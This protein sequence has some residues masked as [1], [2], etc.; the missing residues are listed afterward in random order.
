[1]FQPYS[2]VNITNW[3]KVQGWEYR[4]NSVFVLKNSHETETSLP[5]FAFIVKMI[6]MDPKAFFLVLHILKTLR[7]NEHFHSFEVE[8]TANSIVVSIDSLSEYEP[9]WILKN[10]DQFSES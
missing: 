2:F 7:F 3:V 10:F 9:L 5:E 6:V 1:M 4:E 8:G